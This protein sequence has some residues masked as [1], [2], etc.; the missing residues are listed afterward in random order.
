GP[1]EAGVTDHAFVSPG[2]PARRGHQGDAHGDKSADSHPPGSTGAGC[3]PAKD[4]WRC[5]ISTE[6]ARLA[7]SPDRRQGRTH[8]NLPGAGSCS[9]G[10][11]RTRERCEHSRRLRHGRGGHYRRDELVAN[12]LDSRAGIPEEGG[13]SMTGDGGE[14]I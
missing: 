4:A 8:K 11:L 14:M 9:S 6:V 12:V 1:G 7:S 10:G 13:I 2:E 5:A 3:T